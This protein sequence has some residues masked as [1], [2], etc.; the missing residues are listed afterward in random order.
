[1]FGQTPWCKQR[2]TVRALLG[3]SILGTV[4]TL[5]ID[6]IRTRMMNQHIDPAKNRLNYAH[7]WEAGLKA[8]KYEGLNSLFVG[9]YPYF[10]KVFIY[11]ASVSR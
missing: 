7:S 1:M 9:M 4:Y 2:L 6:N 5:P 3:A 10:F 11:M 8:V